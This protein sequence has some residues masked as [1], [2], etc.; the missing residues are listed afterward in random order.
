M[1]SFEENLKKFKRFEDS[2]L[3][4]ACSEFCV[5]SSKTSAWF[6]HKT[7]I[8]VWEYLLFIWRIFPKSL[9]K[10]SKTKFCY[11]I[12]QEVNRRKSAVFF[13]FWFKWSFE[14][15]RG[16]YFQILS[17]SSFLFIETLFLKSN[18]C[19]QILKQK[20]LSHLIFNN[21]A[22][23]LVFSKNLHNSP[24]GSFRINRK[25]VVSEKTKND[26]PIQKQL[27]TAKV[28]VHFWSYVPWKRA[29]VHF[30]IFTRNLE[31]FPKSIHFLLSILH[32]F[33]LGN[34]PKKHHS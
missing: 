19:L 29:I 27:I 12:S 24:R 32:N 18:K 14:N 16:K 17:R 10:I 30:L 20:R 3:L 26:R 13:S 2:A 28:D 15:I 1:V 11:I 22:S 6:F 21:V 31:R 7:S 9:S 5:L 23:P 34:I 25:N 33:S 8:L 4:R